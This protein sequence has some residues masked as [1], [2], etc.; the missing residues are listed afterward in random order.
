MSRKSFVAFWVKSFVVLIKSP[1]RQLPYSVSL[2]TCSR[3]SAP[4][5]EQPSRFSGA[6]S[7]WAPREIFERRLQFLCWLSPFSLVDLKASQRRL[8]PDPSR[9]DKLCEHMSHSRDRIA[10]EAFSPKNWQSQT[11]YGTP[12]ISVGNR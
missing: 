11:K 2:E 8:S 5:L 10:F 1:L 9:P 4:R 6:D 3:G 7:S 12:A